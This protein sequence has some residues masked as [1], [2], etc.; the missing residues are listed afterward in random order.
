MAL[1]Q[2][3]KELMNQH[4]ENVKNSNPLQLGPKMWNQVC[5]AIDDAEDYRRANAT[6]NKDGFLKTKPITPR[7][8]ANILEKYFEFARIVENP[9]STKDRATAPLMYFDTDKGIYI[10]DSNLI[11]DIVSKVEKSIDKNGGD[12]I[13]YWLL[14]E[15]PYK[16]RTTNKNRIPVGNGVFNMITKELENYDKY[17]FTSKIDT[18]YIDNPSEPNKNG[19]TPSQWITQDICEGDTEKEKLFWQSIYC[20]VNPNDNKKGALML[21]DDGQ[22]NTGKGTF[23]ELIT[24]LVGKDNRADLK[25]EQFQ[26]D[27]KVSKAVNASLIVGDDNT[28]NDY[29]KDPSN[30]K[31]IIAKE[32]ILY[33]PKFEKP[34]SA[35]ITAFVVQSMNGMPQ[36]KDKS[37]ALFDR[38]RI[39]KFNKRYEGK[40]LNTNVKDVYVKDKGVLEWLLYHALQVKPFKRMIK[41][42]ESN[43]VIHNSRVDDNPLLAFVEDHLEE[44]TSERI[45]TIALFNIYRTVYNAENGKKTLY[46]QRKFTTQ[47]KPLMAQKGWEYLKN[48]RVSDGWNEEDKEHFYKKYDTNYLQGT[49]K[50]YLYQFTIEPTDRG[51]FIKT[52]K[53]QKS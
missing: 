32:S 45:P 41:T 21:V 12:K 17:V 1:D 44:F 29:I 36:F 30:L 19:W 31:S 9:T 20:A 15:S 7:T 47:V 23:Q 49:G 52:N 33:N 11:L 37:G 50:G 6:K 5:E 8:C 14:H 22:G 2:N 26:N 42:K 39:L 35:T 18:N 40:E 46:S 16:Q 34:F 38:F 51:V 3:T 25:M 43:A 4:D 27:F 13:L 53:L 10:H 48:G 24:Q 28:P